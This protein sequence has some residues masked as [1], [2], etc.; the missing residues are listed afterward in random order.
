MTS[1]TSP[2]RS[3]VPSLDGTA[4]AYD[5]FGAGEGLIVIGGGLSTARDYAPFARALAQSFAVHVIERRGRDASGPQGP[6]YSIERELDDLFAVQAA[7][8]AAAVFGHSYGGLIRLQRQAP[9]SGRPLPGA[10]S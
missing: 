2:A 8:G 10:P 1:V 4:I 9:T 6:D 3:T 7:T 5:S